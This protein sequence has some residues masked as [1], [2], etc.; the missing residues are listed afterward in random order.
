MPAVLRALRAGTL[1]HAAERV[2]TQ[3]ALAERA[4]ETLLIGHTE[5]FRD[6]DTFEDLRTLI[7]PPLAAGR[8]GLRAWSVGCSKG[9]ELQSAALLLAERGILAGSVLR[10]SDC[11]AAAIAAAQ[12]GSTL[13]LLASLPAQFDSLRRFV[14]ADFGAAIAAV[15]WVVEDALSA[16]Y[17]KSSWD[18]VFC[19]NL[20]IYLDAQSSQRLWA[21][22]VAALAPGGVLVTGRA[23]RPPANLPLARLAKCIYQLEGGSP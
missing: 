20:A 1:G 15:S 12:T 22:L 16:D 23:E 14:D 7:L 4:L 9:V 13:R 3:P 18:L 11:R 10:G 2:A 8:S 19:R 21:R 6:A 17:A 5:S